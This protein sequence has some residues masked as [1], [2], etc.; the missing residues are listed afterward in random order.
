M[1]YRA[2]GPSAYDGTAGVGLFLANLAAVTGDE[3][4]RR[5][6]VAALRLAVER[7]PAL[8]SAERDGLHAGAVGIALAA[9]R[10]AALLGEEQLDAGARGLLRDLRLPSGPRRCPDVVMGGA[11]TIL[12]LLALAG[13]LDDPALLQPAAEAGAQLLDAATVTRH[14]WSWAIPGRRFPHH[15]CGLSHGAGGIGWALAELYAATGDAR[16]REAALGA[17]DYERSWLDQLTGTWPDLRVE[18][19]AP[20]PPGGLRTTGPGATARPASH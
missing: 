16:F 17:F 5:T 4:A 20:R 12:G 14:G 3:R 10:V 2:L 19:A 13:V 11:G 9:A 6:S 15:L 7:A 18:R 1:D 8:P